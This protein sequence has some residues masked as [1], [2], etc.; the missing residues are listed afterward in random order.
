MPGLRPTLLSYGVQD[1]GS[2]YY[3]FMV[4]EQL[5]PSLADLLKACG[6]TFTIA[7]TLKL[8]IQLVSTAMLAIVAFG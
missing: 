7:T 4:L 3:S 1:H 6:G 2:Q 8:A 5:G